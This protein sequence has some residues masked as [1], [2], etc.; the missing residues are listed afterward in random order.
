[1]IRGAEQA[2]IRQI[3]NKVRQKPGRPLYFGETDHQVIFGLPG[4]AAAVMN[5]FYQYVLPAIEKLSNFK[6]APKKNW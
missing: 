6:V 3:F 1:M 2:G 5:S 4:N